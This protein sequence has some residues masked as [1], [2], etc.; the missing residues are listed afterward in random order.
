MLFTLLSFSKSQISECRNHI[1]GDD[2]EILNASSDPVQSRTKQTEGNSLLIS[3]PSVRGEIS[4][5]EKEKDSTIKKITFFSPH[6]G[7]ETAD[8]FK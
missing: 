1:P 4:I 7:R 2:A 6:V 8:T 5:R 3:G